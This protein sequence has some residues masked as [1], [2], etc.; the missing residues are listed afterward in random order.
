MAGWDI[1][2]RNIAVFGLLVVVVYFVCLWMVRL[3][4]RRTARKGPRL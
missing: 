4:D 1:L 2:F 3:E